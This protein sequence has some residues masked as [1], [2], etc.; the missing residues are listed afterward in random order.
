MLGVMTI[1]LA[2]MV[3]TRATVLC[4][5]VAKVWSRALGL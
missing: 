5:F 1:W 2:L 4:D 3:I